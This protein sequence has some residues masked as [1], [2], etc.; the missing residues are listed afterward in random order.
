MVCNRPICFQRVRA[1][2]VAEVLT[3]LALGS[4]GAVSHKV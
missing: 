1:Y 3:C 4:V 2:A